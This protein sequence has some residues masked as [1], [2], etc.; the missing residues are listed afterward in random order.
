MPE[1]HNPYDWQRINP[2]LFYGRVDQLNNLLD[3]LVKGQSFGLAGGRRMGKTTLLRRLEQD[4]FSFAQQAK[5][6][7]LFVVPVYLDIP[8][9][10][11]SKTANTLYQGILQQV[12]N[13]INQLEPN[14]ISQQ[15]EITAFNFSNQLQTILNILAKNHRPQIIFLFDEIEPIVNAE[16]GNGFFAQWRSLLHNTP[17]L[18]PYIS[19]LFTGASELFSIAHDIGSPLGNILVWQELVLFSQNNTALLMREPSQ[20]NWPDDFVADVFNVTGGHPWLI[21]YVMQIVS[22]NTIENAPQT[23][24]EAKVQFLKEQNIS[25]ENWWHKFDHLTQII[26]AQLV[27]QGPLSRQ[28]IL[29]GYHNTSRANRGLSIL[30]HTGVIKIDEETDTVTVAGFLFKTWF[31]KFAII[32]V[33]PTLADQVDLLLKKVERQLRKTLTEHLNNKYKPSWLH[34]QIQKKSP[35]QWQEILKRAKQPPQATLSN[36]I[37]LANLNLG[38]LFDL[39]LSEW[40]S[41]SSTF[42]NLSPD[43]RKAKTRFEERK[44]HLVYVRNKLRHVNED[45]LSGDDLL[46]AQIYCTDL[47]K[48]LNALST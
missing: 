13:Q 31:N 32:K 30:A 43:L 36:Q 39:M 12:I 10:S 27:Q 15:S 24:Q 42:T 29:A 21:Q 34:K 19:A 14:L 38:Y 25:F 7:S 45:Q 33:T 8:V 5:K 46:K 9:L 47:L 37:I 48:P 41:L 28:E 35:K 11:A 22:N 18:S 6:S 44:D 40:L 23:L 1:F 2:N 16:W 3:R 17:N 26:Y 20:Y 4:L